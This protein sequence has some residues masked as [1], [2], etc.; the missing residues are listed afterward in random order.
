MNTD[1]KNHSLTESPTLKTFPVISVGMADQI[2]FDMRNHRT[3]RKTI[4]R[5]GVIYD[6]R[7]MT[8]EEAEKVW[9][10]LHIKNLSK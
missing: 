2:E 9:E 10:E 4:E 7:K 3:A 1:T 5:N 6:I 8:D